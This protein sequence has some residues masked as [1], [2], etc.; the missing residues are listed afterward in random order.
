MKNIK[1][2]LG[3]RSYPVIVGKGAICSLNRHLRA[4]AAGDLAC[5]VANARVRRLWGR[6]LSNG[7][8][9]AGCRFY[10]HTIPDSELGKSWL[11][12]ADIVNGLAAYAGKGKIFVIALGGGVTGDVAGFAASVFKRGVPFIQIPTTLL[13]QVDS[14]IGGKNGV[15]L[16][17][18]KNLAGTFYQPKLVL[19][20]MDFLSTLDRRQLNSGM[21]EVIKYGFIA[22]SSLL[23][24]LEVAR[25]KIVKR[26]PEA[27]EF[28][29]SHCSSIKARYVERDEFDTGEIRMALN[30]GHTF[31]H[32]LEAAAGFR[33]YNHGE[34]VGWGML[35]ALRL[36]E[37]LGILKDKNA[38]TR[39][40]R[41]L[42]AYGLPLKARGIDTG[43]LLSAFGRDKKFVGGMNRM[44]ILEKPGM[45]GIKKNI[46]LKMIKEE[47][48]VM[49]VN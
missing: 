20:D 2:R 38:L 48:R 24:F 31:G 7:L 21:A 8:K 23:N 19:S 25:E 34:A 40:E 29:V 39:L 4:S 45:V 49:A 46:P 35:C 1:V 17:T 32:A 18:G 14:A 9:K 28:I 15:D 26:I 22:D 27:M 30:F 12:A 36:S 13:A 6:T 10:F 11:H 47:I 42:L 43:R 41:L 37:K 33:R 3:E 44:V 5:I 16:R